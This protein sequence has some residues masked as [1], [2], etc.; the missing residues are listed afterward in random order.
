MH[1]LLNIYRD[2]MEIMMWFYTGPCILFWMVEWYTS[3]RVVRQFGI[4]QEISP[5]TLDFVDDLHIILHEPHYYID[6]SRK[7]EDYIV[8]WNARLQ[9]IVPMM[10]Y[11]TRVHGGT[12]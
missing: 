10:S 5:H 7:F 8:L 6:W 12:M 3:E 9:R 4:I 1:E 2:D 11:E